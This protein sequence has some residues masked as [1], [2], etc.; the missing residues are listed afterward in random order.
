MRRAEA[1]AGGAG[2]C[3]RSLG[4]AQPPGALAVLGR[5]GH[6]RVRA[7]ETSHNQRH[8]FKRHDSTLSEKTRIPRTDSIRH[9]RSR[10]RRAS[11]ALAAGLL[12]RICATELGK[13]WNSWRGAVEL[14]SKS[15]LASAHFRSRT[16]RAA[17]PEW[18]FAAAE[19][20]ALRAAAQDGGR[21]AQ[22]HFFQR[23]ASEA[24]LA[25]R[26]FVASSRLTDRVERLQLR[27][28]RR[29][30]AEGIVQWRLGVW[31]AKRRRLVDQHASRRR[32][33]RALAAWADGALECRKER[34]AAA[35]DGARVV[36]AAWGG[37]RLALAQ[38]L[39][40]EGLLSA[41]K[42]SAR[43]RSARLAA[44]CFRRW[45]DWASAQPLERE[46]LQRALAFWRGQRLFWVFAE[47][48]LCAAENQALESVL[49][50][51]VTIYARALAQRAL[52]SWLLFARDR[53]A[54]RAA[55]ALHAARVMQEALGAWA[56]AAAASR[57]A[58]RKEELAAGLRAVHGGRLLVRALEAWRHAYLLGAMETLA[59]S[60]HGQQVRQRV[61]RH[62]RAHVAVVAV[63][64]ATL[65]RRANRLLHGA[66]T[67]WAQ[68]AR[69][70]A[71]TRWKATVAAE[72]RRSAVLRSFLQR[73]RDAAWCVNPLQA[74]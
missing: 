62:W 31:E 35:H 7:F 52:D 44:A 72:H 3:A 13:A 55:V 71:E 2:G 17:F 19:Q 25:W 40:F 30:R 50:S 10:R 66:L 49:L 15:A 34:R 69:E 27:V 63:T 41:A 42:A 33:G 61:F 32:A 23:A 68:N 9:L 48:R 16:L 37:W 38:T 11:E 12:R 64:E 46:M 39:R 24:L 21:L 43:A 14:A 65:L 22:E 26:Q 74:A 28:A 18:R 67:T 36:L 73:W 59:A 6:A 45:L 53:R 54:A 4:Q 1:R 20:A 56:I 8:R 51:A 29:R 57:E 70:R 47:W 5:A 60:H 58:R